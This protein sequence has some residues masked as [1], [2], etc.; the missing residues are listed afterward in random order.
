MSASHDRNRMS[1]V[2]L[3]AGGVG[4]YLG[5]RLIS[6]GFEVAFL[7]REPR[8]AH[9]RANGLSI[10]SP[11]GNVTTPVKAITAAGE[12]GRADLIILTCKAFDLDAALETVAPALHDGTRLL[13]MLNGVRHID[14]LGERRLP[15]VLL[16]GIAHGALTM[17]P[18]G[19]IAHLSPFFTVIA[20][21]LDG[22]PDRV[23]N[24]FTERLKSANVDA[25]ASADIRAEMW[26]K[27]V[28]LTTLAGMTC[29]MRAS[30]GSIV[31]APSGGRLILQ[32]FD[33]CLGVAE[34]EGFTLEP[35]T[36]ESYR[37]LLTQAGSGLTASMLRDIKSGNRIEADHILGDM[38][39][40]ANSHKL[41]TPM[42]EVAYAHAKA[43]EEDRKGT[44]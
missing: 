2:I 28:F 40:R 33:E 26:A 10:T 27:F 22:Q 4:G 23:L 29:L 12:T 25:R 37:A 35:G 21:S 44:G 39:Q 14:L 19:S 38:L 13:P 34:A 9:L 15:G 11:L 32:L 31:A 30:I 18:D 6:A 7:V 5:A 36:V 8:A 43:Y 41:P 17:R 20:G 1:V 24:T 3:G 16:S 42:L